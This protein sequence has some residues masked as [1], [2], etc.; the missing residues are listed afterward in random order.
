MIKPVGSFWQALL[1]VIVLLGCTVGPKY[2]PPCMQLPCEWHSNASEGMVCAS[3][4][5]FL[6]W[7][8]LND[9]ELNSLIDRAALQNLDLSIAATRLLEARRMLKGKCA[10]FIPHVD[11]SAGY[12]HAQYNK[13]TAH[14]LIG[15]FP[16][17]HHGTKSIDF[18]EVG[19][20]AD[21]EI[22]L[23]GMT[24]HEVN[25]LKAKMD[26][27]QEDYCHIWITLSAE[28][29]RNYVE[30]RGL[31]QRLKVIENNIGAQKETIQLTEG[32]IKT[33]FGSVIDQKQADEQ[34]HLLAAQ[35]PLIQQ[36]ITKAIH[37]LS[38]LVGYAPGDLFCELC[39]SRQL[40]CLPYQKPIGIPSELLRRRPD[41]RRA[42]R[43][44]A[45]ATERVGV[46]VAALFP[47]LS[48]HGFVG[49]IASLCSGS[50]TWYAGPQLLVPIF[51]SKLLKEDVELNKIKVQQACYEYQK[52]VLEALEEAENAIASFHY[53]L[54]RNK[55]LALAQQASRDAYEQT[56]QLYQN[57]LKDYL[58]VLI[59]NRS[60][61]S[62][63][64]SFLQSQM[65]LLFHYIALYKALGGGWDIP[66]CF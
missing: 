45:A 16:K 24:K 30:L 6:W 62:A 65:E 37:R 33:G 50:F 26:S 19:F 32:L 52:T 63:E 31:Q 47:R 10:D 21:W 28:I 29:A 59:A 5:C 48:L 12:G 15:C 36:S 23:F 17:H 64:D 49:E 4:D 54:E 2:V 18:F 25:A 66:C 53:E 43:D 14:D 61:L 3:P 51:N 60:F 34:L 44:L 58:E 41:I 38:I 57:G 39:E 40:P 46:A 9:P 55:S 27:S 7:H 42:E 11:G 13:K 35:A 1:L 20:D 8:Y 22:D 56:F